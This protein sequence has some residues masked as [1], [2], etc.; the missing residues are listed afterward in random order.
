MLEHRSQKL[1]PRHLWLRRLAS[2]TASAAGLVG[3][4]L[5]IGGLGYHYPGDL[6]LI[7]AAYNA[8]M[9][10]TGMGAVD[11]LQTDGAKIFAIAYA[12]FSQLVFIGSVGVLVTPWVHRLLHTVH[13][14]LEEDKS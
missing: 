13:A 8:A 5:G 12:F 6:P 14:E 4:G 1:L 11:R 7:E 3:V 10:L 9:I 2:F